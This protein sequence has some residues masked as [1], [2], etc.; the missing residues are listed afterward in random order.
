MHMYTLFKQQFTL[1]MR[2]L[3]HGSYRIRITNITAEPINF[4]GRL[5][6]RSRFLGQI[7]KTRT[8]QRSVM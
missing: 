1:Y 7:W 2:N 6:I 4:V 5:P 8:L 3:T